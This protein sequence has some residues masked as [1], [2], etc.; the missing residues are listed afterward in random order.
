MKILYIVSLYNFWRS[1][2]VSFDFPY[3]KVLSL[4]K[5]AV[6]PCTSSAEFLRSWGVAVVYSAGGGK[7][8]LGIH[9]YR[10]SR[11]LSIEPAEVLIYIKTTGR[12]SYINLKINQLF[13]WSLIYT[14]KPICDLSCS[15]GGERGVLAAGGWRHRT[16]QVSEEGCSH[17]TQLA[18]QTPIKTAFLCSL[19]YSTRSQ[20]SYLILIISSH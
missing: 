11:I 15:S 19:P 2:C 16:Q 1:E 18:A 8:W 10:I 7:F 17:P 14:I 12:G 3:L 4:P 20:S 13:P 6:V 5:C 9:V